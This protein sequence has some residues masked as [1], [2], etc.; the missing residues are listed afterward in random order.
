MV[1]GYLLYEAV[2]ISVNV[3]KIS[4]NSISGLYYWYYNDDYPEVKCEQLLIKDI[5]ILN[6]RI[7][8]LETR[9]KRKN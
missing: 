9:L 4:Y 3:V 7:E 2:D 8:K 5:E 1:L 6:D